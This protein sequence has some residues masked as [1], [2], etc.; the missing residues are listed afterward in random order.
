MRSLVV[1]STAAVYGAGAADP[2]KF[3]EDMEPRRAAALGL[4]ARTPSRS[5]ATYVGWPGAGPTS[6]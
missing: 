1:K 5:R 2:A 6:P 4:R 3:T